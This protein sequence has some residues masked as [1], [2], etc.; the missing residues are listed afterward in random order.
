MNRSRSVWLAGLACLAVMGL[1]SAALAQGTPAYLKLSVPA[2]ATVEIEGVKTTQT[3]E[4]RRF[5]SPALAAGKNYTYSVKVTWK[6]ADGKPQVKEET[7]KVVP[8]ETV[9]LDLRPAGAAKE[10][11]KPVAKEEKPAAKE[12]KPATKEEKPAAKEEKPA[13]KE[14]KPAAKEDDKKPAAKED[15][16]KDEKKTPDV[17][18]VPTPHA[19]VKRMLELAK[20]TDKD[21]VYDLG[22]GDAR[23]VV[24]A[25]KDFGVKKAMGFDIDPERI[26]DS[27]E[28]VKKNNVG[29]KV[30]IVK[31]DIF[32]QDLSEA[33]VVTLYL[34][35][36]LNVKLIPQLE[37]LKPG[38]RIVSHD[39]DMD[40]V[41]PDVVE[42]IEAADDNGN[43]RTH[44]I[45]LWTVPLKKEK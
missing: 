19:V 34:L 31:K 14:E 13:A 11:P 21:V 45:Y 7:V 44:K 6:D 24:T 27:N 9:T 17:I 39:F 38:S 18:Y 28:N 25:A 5:V 36:T 41:K 22:C 3:G 35:P 30:T 42:D 15:D 2:T 33:N 16:K 32:T 20:V 37:K 29:D 40:G 26:K 43:K 10:D 8:G 23:I 12:E 4:V 1:T